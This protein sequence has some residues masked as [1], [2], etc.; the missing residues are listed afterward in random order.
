[1]EFIKKQK[2]A[3]A[4]ALAAGFTG[5]GA[6]MYFQTRKTTSESSLNTSQDFPKSLTESKR[7]NENYL[8]M[9][10]SIK[11][12]LKESK[13]SLSPKVVIVINQAIITLFEKDFVKSCH[14]GR[15]HRRQVISNMAN[16]MKA[17][18]ETNEK[19]DKLLND[20]TLEVCNDLGI[21]YSY[22]ESQCERISADDPNFSAYI[23]YMIESV[24]LKMKCNRE[25]L[26]NKDEVLQY[27]RYQIDLLKTVNFD[28]FAMDPESLMELKQ[29]YITDMAALKFQI[30]EEDLVKN[31][32]SMA[33]AE[34][35][36]A[37]IELQALIMSD[38]NKEYSQ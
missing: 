15:V 26:P 37:H 1:M 22:L 27:F 21:D 7:L 36:E 18:K 11:E 3:I 19:S 30:E 20:V 34:I 12:L 24:K 2:T 35:G 38:P 17:V 13:D 29:S 16:Y 6:Y 31:P 28:G 9:I 8:R 32:N 5:L 33:S 4:L 10:E 23:Y 14:V 25:V